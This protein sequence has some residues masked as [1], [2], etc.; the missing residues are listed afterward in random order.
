MVLLM[1]GLLAENVSLIMG[2]Y[3]CVL[4]DDES[5]RFAGFAFRY[6][7]TRIAVSRARSRNEFALID[8][9]KSTLVPVERREVAHSVGR[10]T[11]G[12]DLIFR[13]PVAF[14]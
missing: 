4:H 5:G 1:C 12:N 11:D 7:D 3:P 8:R 14:Q 9:R 13:A 6:P 10:E 2:S